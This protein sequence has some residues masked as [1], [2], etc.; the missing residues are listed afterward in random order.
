MRTRIPVRFVLGLL[1]MLWPAAQA[2]ADV[3]PPASELSQFESHWGASLGRDCGFSRRLPSNQSLWLFCD[4]PIYDFTGTLTGFIGGTTAAEGTFSPGLVPTQL[5]EVPTPPGALAGRSPFIGP[6]PFLPNPSNLTR[7]NGTACTASS[8]GYPAAWATGMAQEP[9][10]SPRLLITYMEVCVDS[11]ALLVEGFGVVEYDSAQNTIAAGPTEVFRAPAGAQL[12]AQQQL[13][14]PIFSG[15]NLFLFSSVCDASAFGGCTQGRIFLAKVAA[16][17]SSWQRG[18]SYAYWTSGSP[19]W[20]SSFPLAQSVISGATPSAIT[21]DSYPGKGLAIIEETSIGGSFRV[22]KAP[23]GTFVGAWT[24]GPT[25]SSLA[26]CDAGNGLDLCR[27]LT[28][29]PEI[30]T[31]S[32]LLMSYFDPASNHVM[33]VG[34]PW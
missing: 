8:S 19:S 14:S 11:G 13:G 23:A 34:V 20:T 4:T 22:W 33:V 25:G 28:G 24:L 18:Q 12:A 9:G 16:A 27:A 30:S 29:H 15:G 32:T 6:A 2:A 10:G 26:S 7:A 3:P 5:V 17:A 31:T 21:A 1:A